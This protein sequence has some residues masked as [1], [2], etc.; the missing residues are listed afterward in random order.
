MTFWDSAGDFF[1]I[2]LGDVSQ[3][4]L[5]AGIFA[6]FMLGVLGSVLGT[7]G[8]L[9]AK[10]KLKTEWMGSYAL[11]LAGIA[12]VLLVLLPGF[13]L[14]SLIGLISGLFLI[15]AAV[16]LHLSKIKASGGPAICIVIGIVL[17]LASTAMLLI[18][19]YGGGGL[20]V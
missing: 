7:L 14:L 13:P 15:A 19:I 8:G 5:V 9:A 11:A 2:G 10:L 20:L 12:L 17:D 18:E 6:I 3:A 16:L 4:T 1:G